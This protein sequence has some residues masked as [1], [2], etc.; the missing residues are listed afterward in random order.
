MMINHALKHPDFWSNVQ[1][2][3]LNNELLIIFISGLPVF[4]SFLS[5][6]SIFLSLFSLGSEN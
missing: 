6:I 5:N 3:L 2:L 1:L 4:V